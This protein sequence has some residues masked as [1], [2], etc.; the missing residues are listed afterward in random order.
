MI[1]G[2]GIPFWLVQAVG[3]GVM[4]ARLMLPGLALSFVVEMVT[5]VGLGVLLVTVGL[6]VEGATAALSA[7]F[8]VTCAVVTVASRPRGRAAAGP[9]RRGVD[10]REVRAYAALVS[11]LLLGQIVANNSDVF[12]A[13]AVFAPADA[14]VYAAIALVGR[15]VFF[16]AWS[17]ATVVFPVAAR[18]HAAGRDSGG[19]LRGGLVAVVLIGA[20]CSLGALWLGGPVLAAVL[21]PACGGL[22]VRLAAYA[23]M[24]TLFAA[25]NLVA[26][27]HLS[28]GRV[29]ESA[30]LLGAAL[31]QLALLLLR[32]DDVATL[33]GVQA[34]VM[35]AL[36]AVLA[37]R[38]LLVRGRA[39]A[40]TARAVP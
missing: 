25:A 7:S 5:R 3:R 1:L 15:A 21:G 19:V 23:A 6:G 27:Y 32:H 9:A 24:T 18:R 40:A 17:V 10:P 35:A 37:L 13:K 12:V 28:R 34:V 2:V 20:A 30:I 29:T 38:A 14:G 8:V 16:L 36:V 39:D 11:V 31:V 33:I 26:S 22:S 4:Q